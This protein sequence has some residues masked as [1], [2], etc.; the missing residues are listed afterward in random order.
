MPPVM[1]HP[2][3]FLDVFLALMFTEAI[4]KPIAVRLSKRLMRTVDE[5]I[6]L[7]PD[8]LYENQNCCHEEE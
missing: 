7:I 8:F 3:V 1:T 4:L 5:Q 2:K 6:D